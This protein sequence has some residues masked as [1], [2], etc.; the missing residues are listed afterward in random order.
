MSNPKDLQNLATGH[1]KAN[2]RVKRQEEEAVNVVLD[3]YEFQQTN[4]EQCLSIQVFDQPTNV[5][6]L[7]H[8]DEASIDAY[9]FIN[10]DEEWIVD[11]GC[12]HH[13][14]GND[15]LLSDVRPHHMKKVIVT[16]DNSLHPVTK[17][18]DLN[19]RSILLKDVYHV[20]GLKKNLAS[21]SQITDS[22]RYVLFGPN[23]VQILSNI[24]HIDA[25]VLF[26]GK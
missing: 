23:D 25:D 13:A 4:W 16:A 15:T 3:C 22:G 19:D 20:P 5:T 26:C 7:V 9:A 2:C 12:S 18:G 1:I 21:A 8:Q 6:S 17:E 24:K 14:T 10:Y 11:S